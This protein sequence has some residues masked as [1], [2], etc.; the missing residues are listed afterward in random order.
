MYSNGA[1]FVCRSF[2]VDSFRTSRRE[3]EIMTYFYCDFRNERST[4]AAEVMHSIL[5]QLL[6]QLHDRAVDPENVYN[7]LIEAKE[8][9]GGTQQCKGTRWTCISCGHIVQS[10]ASG[11]PRRMQGYSEFL[12]TLSWQSKTTYNFP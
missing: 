5:A 9:G 11:C 10:E 4:S 8:R 2:V 1:E 6:R 12:S 3:G 7:V